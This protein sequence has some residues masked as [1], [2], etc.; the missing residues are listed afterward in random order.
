MLDIDYSNVKTEYTLI[1]HNRIN[2]YLCN[3]TVKREAKS[4]KNPMMLS[5]VPRWGS[6]IRVWVAGVTCLSKPNIVF[7]PT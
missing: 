6:Y 1:L 3:M 5:T 4:H 7:C 2:K